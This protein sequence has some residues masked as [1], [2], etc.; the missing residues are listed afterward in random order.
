MPETRIDVSVIFTQI[1]HS[2][3][4]RNNRNRNKGNDAGFGD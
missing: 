3:S 2:F 4:Q 1:I